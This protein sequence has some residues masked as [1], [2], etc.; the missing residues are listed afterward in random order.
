MTVYYVNRWAHGA[1][2]G[3][4]GG[5]QLCMAL[6]GSQ[7]YQWQVY[8]CDRE[9]YFICQEQLVVFSVYVLA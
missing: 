1:L 8:P 4:A 6:D 3:V 7:S 2:D 5:G 9:A